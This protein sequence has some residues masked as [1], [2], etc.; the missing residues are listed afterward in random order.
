MGYEY[1]EKKAIFS[2][3]K[4]CHGRGCLACPAEAEKYRPYMLQQQKPA[5]LEEALQSLCEMEPMKSIIEE[6]IRYIESLPPEKRNRPRFA[7]GIYRDCP[8]CDGSG[9]DRC[10][11][12]ADKEYKRQFPK[13]PQP[14]FT[15]DRHDPVGSV[16]KQMGA[17]I[18]PTE[19]LVTP[20]KQIC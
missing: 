17:L 2:H 14:I 8:I 13:G 19:V 10:P 12:E 1:D 20:H 15:I 5:S 9:C 7:D 16:L 4:F 3:C 18:S 11:E 6:H